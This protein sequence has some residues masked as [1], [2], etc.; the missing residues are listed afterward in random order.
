MLLLLLYQDLIQ[1]VALCRQ[2]IRRRCIGSLDK[3]CK[4]EEGGK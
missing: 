3:L 1:W 4:A 2:A